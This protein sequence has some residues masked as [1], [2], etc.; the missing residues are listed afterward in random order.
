MRSVQISI[1][2]CKDSITKGVTLCAMISVYV[3]HPR[4]KVG[5]QLLETLM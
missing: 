4:D 1:L 5:P 3:R 2:S